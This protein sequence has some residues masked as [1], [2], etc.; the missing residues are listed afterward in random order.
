MP[1]RP[2]PCYAL[3][4]V[5]IPARRPMAGAVLNEY[6]AV[7]GNSGRDHTAG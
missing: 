7:E 1:T 6:E 2:D 3:R 4:R 5:G